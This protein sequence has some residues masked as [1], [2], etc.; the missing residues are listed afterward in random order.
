MAFE[1]ALVTPLAGRTTLEMPVPSQGTYVWGIVAVEPT[2]QELYLRRLLVE[3]PKPQQ[4][5]AKQ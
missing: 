4:A 2:R 5:A 3:P 1:R